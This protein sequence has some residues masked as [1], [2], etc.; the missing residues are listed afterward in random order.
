M[1][2]SVEV[3]AG[4]IALVLGGCD[5]ESKGLP[6]GGQERALVLPS[7]INEL[8][9]MRVVGRRYL[10]LH[11]EENLAALVAELRLVRGFTALESEIRKQFVT[12]DVVRV[13]GWIL[14]RT[15]V[16]IYAMVALRN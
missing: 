6:A 1:V 15:E 10:E 8:E 9:S 3:V 11:P 12:G 4:G 13:E 7:A 5:G 14:S 2:T 16:R